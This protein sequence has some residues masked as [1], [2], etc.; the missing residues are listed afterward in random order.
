MY[1]GELFS[2]PKTISEVQIAQLIASDKQAIM[3]KLAYLHATNVVYYQ[4]Q[5]DRPKIT[6]TTERYD[7]TRLPFDKKLFGCLVCGNSIE[8][9]V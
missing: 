3:K 6:F 4:P 5:N 7:I 8:V 1:G 2:N 9:I